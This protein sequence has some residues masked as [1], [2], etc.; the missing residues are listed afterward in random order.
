MDEL[1]KALDEKPELAK[2]LGYDSFL[3]ASI[4][5]M[6]TDAGCHVSMCK[7]YSIGSM[8][9]VVGRSA[10]R[11]LKFTLEI[12]HLSSH[13]HMQ[14]SRLSSADLI[15]WLLTVL[16]RWHA[17][18]AYANRGIRKGSYAGRAKSPLIQ[19]PPQAQLPLT[20]SEARARLWR[21][22]AMSRAEVVRS[23]DRQAVLPKP[24]V[25]NPQR[26]GFALGICG[27]SPT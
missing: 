27:I 9:M 11:S 14:C 22:R 3:C 8:T 17:A 5:L 13:L 24:R 10:G 20:D 2:F 23:A 15:K 26:G 7:K 25:R 6:P 16:L 21:F 12:K 1:Q 19:D 18:F 4:S